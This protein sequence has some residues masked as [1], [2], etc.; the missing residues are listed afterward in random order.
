MPD[1]ELY[2]VSEAIDLEL[3]R[4]SDMQTRQKGFRR[5]TYM[6]DIIRGK[7]LSPRYREAA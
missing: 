4:R 6:A 7:R 3:N 5:T 2:A 1:E